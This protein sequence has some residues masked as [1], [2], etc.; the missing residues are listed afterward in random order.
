MWA[1]TRQEYL[2]GRSTPFGLGTI[3]EAVTK[4]LYSPEAVI[5]IS[6]CDVAFGCMDTAEGRHI[7]NKIA[8]FYV[9][10][11]FDLGV[12]LA[13]DGKGGIDEA[14]SGTLPPTRRIQPSAGWL[15]T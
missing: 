5:E 13:A 7:L 12:H 6:R 8:A 1:S 4:N 10:P 15:T 2:N 9:V 14:R 3:V 11:Y